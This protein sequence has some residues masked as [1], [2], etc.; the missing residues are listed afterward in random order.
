MASSRGTAA[1]DSGP[2]ARLVG[3]GEG[4]GEGEG[5]GDGDT[6]ERLAREPASCRTG[7]GEG[8]RGCG[9]AIRCRPAGH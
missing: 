7:D 8:L 1:A 2:S 5:D 4:E 3:G 6:A 9:D